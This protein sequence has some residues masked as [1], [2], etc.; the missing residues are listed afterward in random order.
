VD[1]KK[2][3]YSVIFATK[4]KQED[5]K[6][7]VNKLSVQL[8]L[9]LFVSILFSSCNEKPEFIGLDLVDEDA[10]LIGYDTTIEVFAYSKI[11]EPILTDE[12][13]VNLLGSM[14]S[15][16]FGLTN[17]SF[18]TQ[19]RT[20]LLNPD[21]GTNPVADSVF[22][23]MV[24]TGA[25]GNLSSE[26]NIKIYRVTENFYIDSTYYS[27]AFVGYDSNSFYADYSFVPDTTPE[28]LVDTAN[29]D[30]TYQAARLKFQLNNQFAVDMFNLQ[31]EDDSAWISNDKF[32]EAFKG[33]YIRPEN[34]STPGEGGI[35]YFDMLTDYSNI[36]LYFHN[37][38]EDSLSLRFQI[39]LNCARVGRYE[40]DYSLSTDPDFV[41]NADSTI[42]GSENLYLQCLGGVST[43]I[44]FPGLTGWN[45]NSIKVINEAML[46]FTLEENLLTD[47]YPPSSKLVMFKYKEDG[48]IDF[49]RDQLQ[50]EAY[51]GGNLNE[52]SHTYS[53]RISLYVQDLLAGEA[54]LG[55][56]LFPNAKSVRANEMKL[57]GMN[58]VS[59]GSVKLKIKYTEIELNQP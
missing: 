41:L 23:T 18:Y 33:L 40:H 16:T 24:Y 50:G 55:L 19:L 58:Q 59:P 57:F 17:A 43:F 34:I 42:S 15:N 49:I 36:S 35:L 13:S 9:F 45:D 10:P 31:T 38:E 22:I 28:T 14:T 2:I 32:I 53:F 25:Y 4:L 37:D 3:L 7:V 21:F 54:D 30:T 52:S 46:E 56:G 20:S 51:F 26:Q 48:S 5:L 8:I 11:E 39:N 44:K 47:F 1:N 12:T 6:E 29:Q 27:N